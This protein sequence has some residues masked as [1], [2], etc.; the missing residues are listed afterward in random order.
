MTLAIDG[1][2]SGTNSSGAGTSVS[3]ST[4]LTTTNPSDMVIAVVLIENNSGTPNPVSNI[5]AT[6]LSFVQRSANSISPGVWLDLEVWYAVASS[7]FND[8]VT[9]NYSNAVTDAAIIAFGISG[10]SNLAAPWDTNLSLPTT[11]NG[12][13]VG[14]P[15]VHNISTSSLNDMVLGFISLFNGTN[16]NSG[17]GFNLVRSIQTGLNNV[18]AVEYQTVSS[19]LSNATISFSGSG[20]TNWTAIADATVGSPASVPFGIIGAFD[21]EW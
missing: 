6:G 9:A 12:S 19:V 8:I 11:G 2:V 15:T 7:T 20:V 16:L 14:G 13:G 3:T 17:A 1:T 4:P 18:L 21:T 5:S 10:V